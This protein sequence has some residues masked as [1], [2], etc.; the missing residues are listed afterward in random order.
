METKISTST[1]RNVTT[2]EYQILRVKL[3]SIEGKNTW[4][5]WKSTIKNRD[6]NSQVYAKFELTTQSHYKTRSKN[7][8]FEHFS[9]QRL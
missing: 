2:Q 7:F 5:L 9:S 4:Q 3:S 6:Y 1:N 8:P